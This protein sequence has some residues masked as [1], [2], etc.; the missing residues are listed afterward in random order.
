[1]FLAQ[2]GDAASPSAP[3]RTASA[4]AARANNSDDGPLEIW[5]IVPGRVL[6][7]KRRAENPRPTA[8]DL[9]AACRR[10]DIG[11]SNVFAR[12]AALHARRTRAATRVQSHPRD[13]LLHSTSTR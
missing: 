10:P 3:T 2:A 1:M 7:G 13:R 5:R 9:P 8:A 6:R 12:M 4:T 11:T